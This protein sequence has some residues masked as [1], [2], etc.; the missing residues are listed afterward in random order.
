MGPNSMT[1]VLARGAED[2]DYT[3]VKTKY[4]R[5]GK[6]AAT[7]NPRREASEETKLP[8]LDLKFPTSRL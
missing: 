5:T 6:R 3:E 7:C 2:T 8:T 4:V 1:G